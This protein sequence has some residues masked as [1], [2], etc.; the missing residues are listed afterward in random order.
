MVDGVIQRLDEG[1]SDDKGS[2]RCVIDGCGWEGNDVSRNVPKR[3]VAVHHP[4]VPYSLERLKPSRQQKRGRPKEEDEEVL[5]ARKEKLKE[6]SREWRRTRQVRRTLDLLTICVPHEDMCVVLWVWINRQAAPP[7]FSKVLEAAKGELNEA[8]RYLLL[9]S[10]HPVR[11][12]SGV[13]LF[14]AFQMILR[15][16]CSPLQRSQQEMSPQS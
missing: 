3:H 5:A 4:N 8:R 10:L 16:P 9:N 15:I 2:Y 6:T 11:Y 13:G 12:P 14:F 1:R 7:P